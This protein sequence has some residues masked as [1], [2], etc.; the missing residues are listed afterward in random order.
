MSRFLVVPKKWRKASGFTMMELLVVVAILMILMIITAIFL[1]PR[2][3]ERARDAQRKSD[4]EE[5]RVH[6]EAYNTD[7]KMYPPEDIMDSAADCGTDNFL[8]YMP[9]ILCDPVTRQPYEY[10]VSDDGQH[11]WLYTNLGD[12]TDPAIV[13]LGCASGCGPDG[14]GDSVPDYNYGIS[15]TVKENQELGPVDPGSYCPCIPGKCGTCCPG[16]T[17]RCNASGSGCYYDKSCTAGD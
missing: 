12:E 4:L 5:Y 6:F 11:Y 8:P 16:A 17:Y 9:A 15:D 7:K 13:N 14:D 2:Y 1:I 10:K 3:I